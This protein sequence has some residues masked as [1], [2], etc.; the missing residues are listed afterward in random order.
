MKLNE[1][2]LYKVN[3]FFLLESIL[4]NLFSTLSALLECMGPN[5]TLGNDSPCGGNALEL[6]VRSIENNTADIALVVGCGNW[7][8][9]IPMY[10]MASLGLLSACADDVRSFRP[11][12]RQRDGFIPGE[13]GAAFFLETAER[14]EQRGAKVLARLRGFGNCSGQPNA[15][16]VGIADEVSAD[17]MKSAME[18]AGLSPQ[19]CAFVCC[20]GSASRAGDR[21]ELMSIARV[22]GRPGAGIPVCGLKPYTGHLGA[23]SDI[24]EIIFSM[25]AAA[26]GVVPATLHFQEPDE[27]FR[28]LV[29]SG[30]HGTTDRRSF[31]SVSCGVAGQSS[32]VAVEVPAG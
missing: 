26:E 19:D 3:P 23:A 2:S 20:H 1:S 8:T 16:G 4:N 32:A 17:S 12:D 31:L 14:A 24:A 7:I 22:F 28:E 11:F 21:S 27:E 15:A 10:E 9:E 6:A 5:T 18:E 29:I 30:T 25:R 13:G